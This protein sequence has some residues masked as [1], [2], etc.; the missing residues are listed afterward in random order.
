MSVLNTQPE[1]V[2]YLGEVNFKLE[3]QKIPNVTYFTQAVTLPEN[4]SCLLFSFVSA[5][6]LRKRN[7]S[8]GERTPSDERWGKALQILS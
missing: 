6:F 2:N 8:F 3:I 5:L 4:T 1:N 7:M